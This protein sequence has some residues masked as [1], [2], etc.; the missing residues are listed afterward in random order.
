MD[1]RRRTTSILLGSLLISALATAAGTSDY[2]AFVKSK[3][4]YAT[5]DV[6]GKA[7]PK[8]EVGKWLTGAAPHTKRKVVLID[9]W[10]TWCPPCRATIPELGKWQK[11]HP[12]DLVVIG[13]TAEKEDVVRE[14]MKKTP[15]PYNVAID[16]ADKMAKEIGVQGIPHV[17]VISPDGVVRWQGFPLDNADKLTDEKLDQIIKAATHNK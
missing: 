1:I 13:I 16:P 8:L 7:A 12:K 10:A 5:N 9:F 2:P 14:F 17:L 6:R 15:M 4:L 3:N 11:A